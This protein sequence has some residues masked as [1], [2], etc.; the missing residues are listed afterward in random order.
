LRIDG[1]QPGRPYEKRTAG[2]AERE[3]L[4]VSDRRQGGFDVGGPPG[5]RVILRDLPLWVNLPVQATCW[6]E[7]RAP[8]P[9]FRVFRCFHDLEGELSLIG[10]SGSRATESASTSGFALA[11][12]G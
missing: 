11:K 7:N 8:E 6:Q 2:R 9:T 5:V 4:A 12:S 1:G 10:I 3:F